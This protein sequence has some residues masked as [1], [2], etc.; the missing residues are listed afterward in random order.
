MITATEYKGSRVM[1]AP[2]DVSLMVLSLIH[3]NN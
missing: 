2:H 3:K 1:A